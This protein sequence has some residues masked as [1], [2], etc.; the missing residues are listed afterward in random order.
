LSHA[1]TR[2][3]EYGR[4]LAVERYLTGRKVKDITAQLATSRTTVYKWVRRFQLEGPAGLMDRS[5]RPLRRLRQVPFYIELQV[6]AARL[7]LHAGPEQLAAELALPTSTI[8]QV[9]RRWAVPHLADLDRIT[10]ELLRAR[11]TD[12]RYEHAR[13]GDLLH[14]D[15][16]NWLWAVP[17]S[18]AP[19]AVSP[20]GRRIRRVGTSTWGG[21]AGNGHHSSGLGAGGAPCSQGCLRGA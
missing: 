15:V 3:N 18:R 2:T 1:D 9:L 5:G 6:L 20:R 13:P 14:V 21:G 11:V 7:E 4:N 16:K 10:G 19:Q 12:Q 8:D 17:S